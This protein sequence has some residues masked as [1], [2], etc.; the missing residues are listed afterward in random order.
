MEVRDAMMQR[1]SVRQFTDSLVPEAALQDL[2][3]CAMAGPSAHNLRPWE[4]YMVKNKALQDKLRLVTR[5][6]TMNSP[7]I[8][9]VAGKLDRTIPGEGNDFWVQD[10][11]AAVE[12]ILLAAT[13]LGLGSCWVGLHPFGQAVKKVRDILGLQENI[14]PLALIHLGYG[15]K[16]PPARTQYDAQRVHIYEENDSEE[17]GK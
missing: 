3:E 15:G 1:R 8:L 10:C 16:T 17:A 14:V 9:I 7:L 12:N 13:S 6:S 5:Y 4:F 2:M 11:S